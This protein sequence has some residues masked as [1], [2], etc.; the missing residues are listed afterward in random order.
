MK[1]IESKLEKTVIEE[2]NS[3]YSWEK[4]ALVLQKLIKN[5]V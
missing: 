2:M 1:A 3:K 5:K 4:S